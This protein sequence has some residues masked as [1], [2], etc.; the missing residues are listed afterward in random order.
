MAAL[1]QHY[2]RL[3]RYQKVLLGV[4]GI[5]LGWYGPFLMNYAF[6]DPGLLRVR[7]TKDPTTGT[8]TAEEKH[9]TKD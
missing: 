8:T 7:G 4:V 2:K 5:V 3:P 1:V 9:S 6:L